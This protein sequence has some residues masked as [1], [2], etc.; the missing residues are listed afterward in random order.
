MQMFELLKARVSAAIL[1]SLLFAKLKMLP[2][3]I[4]NLRAHS[5][6]KY[7]YCVSLNPIYT[8]PL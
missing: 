5:F 7:R 6:L 1:S 3:S 4:P 2:D 8:L